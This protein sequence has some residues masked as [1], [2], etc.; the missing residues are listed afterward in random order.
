MNYEK[1]KN[2]GWGLSKKSLELITSLFEHKFKDKEFVSIVEFGSGVSTIFLID[3]LEKMGKKFNIVSF[4]SDINYAAKIKHENLSLLIKDLEECSDVDFNQMFINKSYDSNK[5]KTKTTP[6]TSRQKNTFYKLNENDVPFEIDFVLLDGSHGNGRSIA[7]LHLVNKLVNGSY[8]FIDDL[9]HYDFEKRLKD[10]FEV[11]CVHKEI[12]LYNNSEDIW[13]NG[14]NCG[15]YE[16]K[17]IN[18]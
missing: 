13:F 3:L 2:G 18:N 4:D 12:I 6:A 15:L 10:I 9:S 5:F 7:F 17:N 16:I 1:Y 8:V 11:D 14:I